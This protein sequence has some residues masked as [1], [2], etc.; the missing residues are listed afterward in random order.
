MTLGRSLGPMKISARMATTASS[1]ES[2]P[3]MSA[4]PGALT[5][6]VVPWRWRRSRLSR[7]RR[8]IDRLLRAGLVAR[9]LARV[10]AALFVVAAMLVVLLVRHAL[11]EALEALRHVAHHR[12]EAVAAEQQQDD[13]R[14]DQDMPYAKSAHGRLLWR[15]I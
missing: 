8:H 7:A 12:R 2:T 6:F 4:L 3:N 10:T 13:D 15:P 14:E 11:F 1:E 5:G 9:Q